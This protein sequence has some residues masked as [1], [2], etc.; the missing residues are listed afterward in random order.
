LTESLEIS[1]VGGTVGLL[2]GSLCLRALVAVGPTDIP[3]LAEAGLDLQVLI[4]AAA[5]T[6]IVGLAA[7]A[8]PVFATRKVDLSVG[9]K[10]GSAGSGAGRGGH[11]LRAGLV[12]AEIA[13]TLIL[14]FGS[15][16]LIRSLI[17]A[18]SRY[19]GFDPDH[20]LA[21]ELQL[22]PSGYKTDESIRQF[23][24]KL[25]DD[26]R[27]EPGVESVGAATCPPSAGDC[28][29]YWYS[30]LGMPAPARDEV[31][32]CLF[33]TADTAYFDA[34]RMRLVAGRGFNDQDHEKEL[35]VAV[36]NEELARK[37]WP[38]AEGAIGQQIKM[39]G[40]YMEGPVYQIVGVVGSVS[41]M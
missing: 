27:A 37:W 18:Q 16:L 40:P 19:P 32:L 7:G 23:Y 1:V 31:P 9:L 3:R 41:Q 39:G 4:F 36:I 21:L 22:P 10:E 30:I 17:A 13:I 6:A 28:G 35:L 20:L 33:N 24:R 14:L 26:L 25:T 38:A 15:G 34:M 5:A 11:V 8:A 29:D 2:L 12:A